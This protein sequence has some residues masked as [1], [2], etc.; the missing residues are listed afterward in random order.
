MDRFNIP[1][2]G[3]F[4]NRSLHHNDTC[5]ICNSN[6]G[7]HSIFIQKEIVMRSKKCRIIG[8]FSV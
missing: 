5:I 4:E 3:I 8:T 7:I 6:F 1:Y 2:L